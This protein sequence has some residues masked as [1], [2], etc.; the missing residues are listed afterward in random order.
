MKKILFALSV[1][2]NLALAGYIFYDVYEKSKTPDF[3]DIHKYD[4]EN[5]ELMK[6]DLD[7]SRVVFIGDSMTEN[8]KNFSPDFFQSNSYVCRGIGGEVSSQILLRFRQDVVDLNPRIVVIN[9][10]INDLIN[11][12]LKYNEFATMDLAMNN[13]RSMADIARA[14]NIEVIM[15]SI[16]P[17]GNIKTSTI[18]TTDIPQTIDSLNVEIKKFALENGFLY[19]DYNT[20]LRNESGGLNAIY[21]YD[22]FHPNKEGYVVMEGVI[23]IEI[24]KLLHK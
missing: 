20:A 19:A 5:K 23:E 7:T 18:E 8:W 17:A 10:G 6:P 16:L 24:D 15:T 9:A 21:A 14:N 12:Y 22:G 4:S 13:I 11:R 1:L 2:L 3:L